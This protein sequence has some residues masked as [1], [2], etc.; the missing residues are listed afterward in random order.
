MRIDL[1]RAPGEF[2]VVGFFVRAFGAC[3]ERRKCSKG[4]RNRF[5]GML[6]HELAETG[7]SGATGKS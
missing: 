3:G 5:L 6:R 7:R 2:F 4:V 1:V